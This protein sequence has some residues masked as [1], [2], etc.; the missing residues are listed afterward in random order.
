MTTERMMFHLQ[1]IA[2][3]LRERAG[4]LTTELVELTAALDD[5]DEVTGRALRQVALTVQE[6]GAAASSIEMV[7]T[8]MSWAVPETGD[9][10][11]RG[12]VL[13]SEVEQLVRVWGD[14]LGKVRRYIAESEADEASRG[15]ENGVENEHAVR[16]YN[17]VNEMRELLH[18]IDDRLPA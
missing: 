11:S 17:K 6:M 2:D 15:V 5:P 1:P 16:L 18:T 9:L 3:D 14:V 13:S 4:Q 8:A 7:P 10:D 12:Q